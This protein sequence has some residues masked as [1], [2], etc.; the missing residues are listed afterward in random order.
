MPEITF[1]EQHGLWSADQTR[2]A[3]EAS[4]R[5]KAEGLESIRLSFPDQHGL[6]RGKTLMADAIADKLGDGCA[7]TTTLLLKDSSHRTVYPVWQSGGGLGRT[8]LTGAADFI[9]VPDPATFKVLP[10]AHKTGWLLCDAYFP[11]GK[12]VSFATRQILRKLIDDLL[13]RGRQ[14]IAGLEAE[15]HIFRVIQDKLKLSEAGNP[16]A[17]PEV[18]LL[19]QGYQ[20]LTET[21]YDELEPILERLRATLAALDLPLRSMEV[22]F[23]PSQVEFTF[24]TQDALAT[25]DAMVLFRSAVKQICQRESLLATFMCRPALENVFSS[26]WHLHQSLVDS[27]SGMNLFASDGSACLSDTGLHFMGGLLDNAAAASVF[28]TPTINGYK[29]Y[30]PHTLAPD[31][32]SWGIDNRGSMIRVCG[33]PGQASSHIENRAGEPAANPYLYIASQLI[34]GRDGMAK[35]LDPGPPCD[36]PYSAEAPGLPASLMEAVAALD[37]SALYRDALGDDFVDYICTIKRAEISRFL[38]EVTDW[39]QREY[40][41]AF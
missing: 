2:L 37:K 10:W 27:E 28:T 13:G 15:F 16:G 9:I 20:Y 32:I 29:R 14:L 34:A 24:G 38:S 26:G 41:Q 5:I 21:R 1:A 7:L 18:E 22:E 40:F 39:E 25:A 17:V 33:T 11:D 12:P 36:L 3:K 30:R 23:G 35:T 31:R 19:A 6:L 4:V 8:E